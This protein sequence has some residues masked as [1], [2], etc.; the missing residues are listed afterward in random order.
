MY[1]PIIVEKT[2]VSIVYISYFL[3]AESCAI[4]L[5]RHTFRGAYLFDVSL[6]DDV[7]ELLIQL[8]G[9]A[10][11]IRLLTGNQGATRP[12]EGVN[13]HRVCHR[14]V[15]NWIGQKRNGLHG[16][17]VT[18]LLGLVELPDGGLFSSGVPLVLAVFLPAVENRLMLPLVRGSPQYQRLLFPDT[19][20]G[21]VEPG[22]VKRLA[23]I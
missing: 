11:A 12:A 21:E 4:T 15:L 7:T 18:V 13:H 6:Y 3:K 22:S 8:Y 20:A 17:V 10:D 23:E 2:G 9:I 19:A 14:A 1:V 5:D 16:G